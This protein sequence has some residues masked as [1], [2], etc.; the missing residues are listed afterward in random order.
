MAQKF[1]AKLTSAQLALARQFET[2]GL[3][4]ISQ[5]VKA[6]ERGK[7]TRINEWKRALVAQED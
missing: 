3:T 4:S 5:A 2:A 7:T 1:A 6:F